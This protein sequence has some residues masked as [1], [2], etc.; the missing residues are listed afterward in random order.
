MASAI[1]HFP[2]RPP[3][4]NTNRRDHWGKESVTKHYRDWAAV[5]AHG[6]RPLQPPVEVH[7]QPVT[8]DGRRADAGACFE[9]VKAIIDGLVDAGLIP[10]DGPNIVKCLHLHAPEVGE[11]DRLVIE[12]VEVDR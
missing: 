12:L 9:V 4:V 1:F 6:K 2:G 5:E 11:D 7:A 10:D 8:I 3:R